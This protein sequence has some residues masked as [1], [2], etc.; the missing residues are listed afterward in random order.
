MMDRKYAV[1][2]VLI[3]EDISIVERYQNGESTY[4]IA[5]TYST[6]PAYVRDVLKENN[7]KRRNRSEVNHMIFANHTKL[8]NDTLQKLDG[9]LLGDGSIA[10]VGIQAFFQ[11]TSKYE[12]YIQYVKNI[13]EQNDLVCRIYKIFDKTYKTYAYKLTTKCTIQLAEIYNKW[14]IGAKKINKY[15]AG[16]KKIVPMDVELSAP[17]IRNWI[18]DDG[19][20]SK[21]K[22]HLRL[23]TCSFTID[24]CEFLAEK[25]NKFVGDDTIH[26]TNKQKYPVIYASKKATRALLD[27]IGAPDVS[28]FQYKWSN[29]LNLQ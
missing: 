18:M 22:G 20:V 4:D 2:T 6:H 7:I 1:K 9:W 29:N 5:K 8:N 26:V 21:E 23:C 13:I 14:Y 15:Y 28:C 12:E 10:F 24:E 17:A 11:F 3:G 25:L 27:K 16:A 19:S